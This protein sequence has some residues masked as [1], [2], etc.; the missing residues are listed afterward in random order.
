LCEFNSV[1]TFIDVEV[2]CKHQKVTLVYR[3]V[4]VLPLLKRAL[5]QSQFDDVYLPIMVRI[6]KIAHSMNLAILKYVGTHFFSFCISSV[7]ADYSRRKSSNRWNAIPE[8]ED[9]LNSSV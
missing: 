2:G 8:L 5:E 9:S 1:E 3:A 7:R 4:K 6:D